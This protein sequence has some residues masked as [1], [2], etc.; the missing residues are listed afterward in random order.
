MRKLNTIEKLLF[1]SALGMC[2]EVL[3]TAL[4]DFILSPN[5]ILR[6]YSYICMIFIWGPAFYAIEFYGKK[7]IAFRVGVIWRRILCIICSWIVEYACGWF[8]QYATGSCP[9][10]YSHATF[11]V[12]GLIRLDYFPCWALMASIVEYIYPYLDTINLQN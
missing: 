6:G 8:L 12:H 3:F 4:F 1:Y 9:W 2:I 7:L 5:T 10:D 11:H